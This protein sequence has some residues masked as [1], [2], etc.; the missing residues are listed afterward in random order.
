MLD[1]LNATGISPDMKVYSW[2]MFVRN[3]VRN[4]FLR[5]TVQ[6]CPWSVPLSAAWQRHA[7][8]NGSNKR[9][10]SV[11]L[12]TSPAKIDAHISTRMSPNVFKVVAVARFIRTICHKA[13]QV[14]DT[15]HEGMFYVCVVVV[16]NDFDITCSDSFI[17]HRLSDAARRWIR[18]CVHPESA[19]SFR[20]L[21]CCR[22]SNMVAFPS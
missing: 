11:V 19:G 4:L 5:R 2:N 15:L 14:F 6:T 16:T 9:V 3:I 21:L 12:I 13:L 22:S 1:Q 10:R 20:N 8:V 17:P 18:G 7:S